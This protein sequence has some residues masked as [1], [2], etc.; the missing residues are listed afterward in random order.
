VK[1]FSNRAPLILA[2]GSP[3]RRS[4]LEDL[5][6]NFT[7]CPVSIDETPFSGE[8]GG[9]FVVRMA[10]EKA[11]VAGENHCN[12]WI[13]AGDTVVCLDGRILGKPVDQEDAVSM[14]MSLSGREHTVRTGLCLMNAGKKLIRS[15]SV[16]TGVLFA[17]FD[18]STA[19]AYAGT[20]E[21]TDKAGAYGIQGKGAFL[22]RAVKGSY[23]NVVGMPLHELVEMLIKNNVIEPR[24][25][26]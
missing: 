16:K 15:C 24:R 23:T 11:A 26:Y 22:V 9:E 13:I 6:V 19:R 8:D 10:R 5:G 4:Y 14:L 2:S 18:M 20:G 25:L 12:S 7:V 17:G 3:R 1:I 21:W